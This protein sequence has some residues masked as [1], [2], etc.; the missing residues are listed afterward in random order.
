[1]QVPEIKEKESLKKFLDLIDRYGE[2]E[3]RDVTIDVEELELSVNADAQAINPIVVREELGRTLAEVGRVLLGSPITT[4]TPIQSQQQIIEP[5]KPKITD[6]VEIGYSPPKSEYSG[7][8]VEVTIGA[9]KTAKS[10]FLA[11]LRF[12]LITIGKE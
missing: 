1:M 7:R 11:C 2:V 8:I 4:P 9:T 3:L 10:V 6:M 12:I 5:Q